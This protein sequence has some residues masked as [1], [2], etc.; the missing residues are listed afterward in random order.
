MSV[1]ETAG[2]L[3]MLEGSQGEDSTSLNGNAGHLG[4]SAGNIAGRSGQTGGQGAQPGV[5]P[6]S[7]QDVAVL[8]SIDVAGKAPGTG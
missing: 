6:A 3:E 1:N 8:A 5:A 4:G 7:T 2:C